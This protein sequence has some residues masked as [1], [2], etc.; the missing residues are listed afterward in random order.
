VKL[1]KNRLE[2]KEGWDKHYSKYN[3]DTKERIMKK[4][5]HMKQPLQGRGLKKSKF[6]VEEVGQYRIAFY[7]EVNVKEIH[8]IGTHKQ[9]EKWYKRE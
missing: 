4:L 9:Y 2:F 1:E 7:Q 6:L 5:E 3:V 8:F